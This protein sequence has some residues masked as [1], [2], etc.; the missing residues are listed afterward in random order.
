[1]RRLSQT[2]AA[3][4]AA[5]LVACSGDPPTAP[6]ALATD[7]APTI[8]T[9]AVRMSRVAN[10][11]LKQLRDGVTARKLGDSARV[12]RA[13]HV[14]RFIHAAD[15]AVSIS[16]SG[17]GSARFDD[18]PEST[19]PPTPPAWGWFVD[20][21][22][23]TDLCLSC[24]SVTGFMES[25]IV[26]IISSSTS[27]S[28]QTGGRS[29]SPSS[30]VNSCLGAFCM[31]SID[32][33][34]IVD[35]RVNSA[36]GTATSTASY[37]VRVLYINWALSTKTTFDQDEC[38]TTP[39]IPVTLGASSISVG[40][41]TQ[42]SSPCVG[43]PEWSTNAPHIARVSSTGLITGAGAGSAEI[44]VTCGANR[45]SAIINVTLAETQQTAGACDDPMTPMVETCDDPSAPT[46]APYGV[47]YTRDGRYGE[48][49]SVWYTEDYRGYTAVCD[50]TDWY[51][52]NAD[53]TAAHYVGTDV[54][55]CW[56]EPYV[57]NQ[58]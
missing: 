50:V 1:M 6:R 23:F 31:S 46:Y 52:W 4:G 56:L 12:E 10:G 47:T 58:D 54:N 55:Y 16:R 8:D 53:H 30:G 51:E 24:K 41:T 25:S 57:G 5:M 48:F 26:G 17:I 2:L 28:I 37:L 15:S 21:G 36:Q 19:D 38:Q 44:S 35:C 3:A 33:T 49:P 29:Y 34:P 11:Y 22:T 42:A 39:L 40:A 14:Q 18:V 43:L 45:G 13:L 27:A 9:Q 20:A 7:P 32:L